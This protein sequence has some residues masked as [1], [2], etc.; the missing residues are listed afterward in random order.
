MLRGGQSTVDFDAAD[1][2]HLYV[3]TMKTINFRDDIPSIPLHNFEDHYK[4]VFDLISMQNATE[5]FQY[6]KLIGEPRRLELKFTF[7][8]EHVTALNVLGKR[9][10]STLFLE[11][12]LKMDNAALQ[13]KLNR[14]L[15]LK[16]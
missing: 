15:L 1:I 10:S 3:T 6:P 4:L 13:Q 8:L 16:Y 2:C 12:L 14:I 11:R 5:N 9:L 7:P